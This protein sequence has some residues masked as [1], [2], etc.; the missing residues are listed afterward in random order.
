MPLTRKMLIVGWLVLLALLGSAAAADGGGAGRAQPVSQRFLWG[1]WIGKQFTGTEPPWSWQ[2]VK[3]FETR[4]AGGRHVS[5]V[6]WG[7]GTPWE[8]NFNYW[9]S[10]L[11]RVRS[12]GALS[13]GDMETA[14]ASLRQIANG[15]YDTA[16]RT[17]ASQ[18]R[19]WGHPMLLR[20]DW[21]MNGGW[22][23]WGT[24]SSSRNTPA[25]FIA[26]WRLVHDIF[27]AA[28]ASNVQ[29]VWCPN[30]QPPRHAM[31]KLASL[32][33]GSAYVD[34]TC[35]DGYNF[36]KPWTTFA[37]LFGSSYHQ[38]MRIAPTKPMLIGEIA[39]TAHGGN[40]ARW[41]RSMFRALATRFSAIDGLV[42]FD[43]SAEVDGQ[44]FDW[45]L[46]TSRG[47]SAAF[48]RGIRS[49]LARRS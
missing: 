19:N 10:P 27:T 7:V 16:L 37:R 31:T 32:Y 33:P 22:E 17:W 42:W 43:K 28:G 1:A 15:A 36:G 35:L 44:S 11:N 6:H 29:W 26:F 4:N 40:K 30:T 48:N 45:P 39:S 12:S 41:I 47:A 18:A 38:V 21:E 13:L 49:T 2:A 46:E 24:R 3:D 20:L 23:P 8:H 34:W 25:D 9:L 5:L 14:S